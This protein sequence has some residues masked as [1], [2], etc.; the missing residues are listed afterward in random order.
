MFTTFLASLGERIVG[1]GISTD[2]T[3]GQPVT[4]K[5]QGLAP[6]NHTLLTFHNA[7]DKLDTAAT[8]SISVDGNTVLTVSLEQQTRTLHHLT[9]S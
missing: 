3:T 4:L 1:E 5:I 9:T 2:T 8:L 7:W 6:G